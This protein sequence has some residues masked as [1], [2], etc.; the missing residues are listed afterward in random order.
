MGI[1]TQAK[2]IL[3]KLCRV[4][5]IDGPLRKLWRKS[6]RYRLHVS[7]QELTWM[8]EAALERENQRHEEARQREEAQRK[9]EQR[10]KEAQREE[11][12]R[13]LSAQQHHD[14]ILRILQSVKAA[15]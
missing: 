12:K 4:A 10:Q 2:A 6:S 3:K 5:H 8:R 13:Q 11:E 15:L 9:E 7:N 14:H 1:S